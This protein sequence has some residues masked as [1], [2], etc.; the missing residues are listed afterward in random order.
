M[1]LAL[2]SQGRAQALR[3]PDAA[4]LQRAACGAALP[5]DQVLVFGVV[6]DG[7]QAPIAGI[8]VVALWTEAVI[9]RNGSET[10]LR[11][12][13]D[14]TTTDGTYALCG[15]PRDIRIALRAGEDPLRSGELMLEMGATSALER[16]LVASDGSTRTV[17]TGLVRTPA[18]NPAVGVVSLAD[19][20]EVTTRADSSGRFRLEGVPR[21]S[22]QLVLRSIG[23]SPLYLDVTP[24]GPLVDL[25]EVTLPF[26]VQM[27]SEVRIS[28]TAISRERSAFN[29]RRMSLNGIFMDS[30]FLGRFAWRSANALSTAG[31]LIR[32]RSVPGGE[33]IRLRYGI[34][35]CWPLVFLDGRNIGRQ[36]EASGRP[37]SV[38]P[39]ELGAL[40]NEAMRIEVY[41]APFAP[42]EF[43]DFEGCG[44][45]VIWLR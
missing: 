9:S 25:G 8:Q 44:A 32:G 33:Y 2:P 24:D 21:R 3:G 5:D 11:A 20:P 40:L 18:G 12:S 15:V 42:P 37:G 16:D 39:S 41:A 7:Q 22:S 34:D 27:L 19:G 4:L 38:A 26:A 14:T 23:Y 1:L 36:V 10:L 45:F 35:E 31:N 43:A 6:R 13:V 17:V 30:T 29:E 28:E